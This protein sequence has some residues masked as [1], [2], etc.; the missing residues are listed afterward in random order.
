MDSQIKFVK[1]CQFV[2]SGLFLA[3]IASSSQAQDVGVTATEILLGE[4]QPMSGAASFLGKAGVA[5]SRLAIAEINAAGGING[6]KLRAIYEDDGYVPARSVSALKKLIDSDKV[7]GITGTSGS[8][9]MMAMMPIIEEAKI[10]TIVHLSPSPSVVSPR[11]PSVFMIGPSHD[12]GAYAPIRYMVE[13]MN[14]K[15]A[16][17]GILYQDDDFGKALLAGYQKAVKEFGLASVAEIPFKRGTKDFSA[18]VLTLKK[19]GATAIYLGTLTTESASIM[20][21]LRRLDMNV[22]LSTNFSGQLPVAINIAAPSGYQYLIP[23]YYASNYDPAGIALMA[24]AKKH[25]T[26]DEYSNFNRYTISGYIGTQVF[27][28]GI[29]RCGADVTRTCVIEQLDK[30][31]DFKVGGLSGPISLDNQ[32]GQAMMPIRLFQ[33]EPQS[34][35][36]KAL[37]DFVTY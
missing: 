6:R 26:A 14:N 32:K 23:D 21:E 17:F 18:E 5:G 3:L 37:T 25:L 36:V 4:V 7:F 22:T 27:A 16:K 35:T 1:T 11:R 19:N 29:R 8:S 33:A 15:D 20:K 10:P 28:E 9:H 24:S 31:H 2:C 13:K 12:Y 30:L 34:G